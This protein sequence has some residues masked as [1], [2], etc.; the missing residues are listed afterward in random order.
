[1]SLRIGRID[2]RTDKKTSWPMIGRID[3][4]CYTTVQRQRAV[5]PTSY[6]LHIHNIGQNGPYRRAPLK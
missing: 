4:M 6:T 3:P 2:A 5:G 1:M